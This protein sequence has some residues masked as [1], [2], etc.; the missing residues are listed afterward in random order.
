LLHIDAAW[1]STDVLIPRRK[2]DLSPKVETFVAQL[3]CPAGVAREVGKMERLIMS[4]AAVAFLT[5]ASA[6]YAQNPGTDSP[7]Q[8]QR[9]RTVIQDRG[10]GSNLGRIPRPH[11]HRYY[12][13]YH[14]YWR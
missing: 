5:G 14:Y 7:G 9:P 1:S 2:H 6:A 8:D 10:N 4:L 3:R 11:V 12:Y 13:H